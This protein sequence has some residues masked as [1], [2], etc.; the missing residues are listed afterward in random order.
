MSEARAPKQTETFKMDEPAE[1]PEQTR[2]ELME[3]LA[4]LKDALLPDAGT[5]HRLGLTRDGRVTI[6]FL[7]TGAIYEPS[8][9]ELC[10]LYTDVLRLAQL[11][12]GSGPIPVQPEVTWLQARAGAYCGDLL[13]YCKSLKFDANQTEQSAP[14]KA[15]GGKGLQIE[16]RILKTLSDKEDSLQWSCRKW[17]LYLGCAP[18]TVRGTKTWNKTLKIFRISA[19]LAASQKMDDGRTHPQGRRKSKPKSN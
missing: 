3:R 13:T 11:A 16:A 19:A 1:S 9:R 5:I 15:R 18:S 7:Q 10:S 2:Q 8:Y 6:H 14:V 4:A 17:A 12:M